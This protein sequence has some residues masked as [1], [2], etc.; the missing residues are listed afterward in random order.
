VPSTQTAHEEKIMKALLLLTLALTT[1][2]F[3]GGG[4]GFNPLPEIRK[5]SIICDTKSNS[6]RFNRVHFVFGEDRQGNSLGEIQLLDM[7]TRIIFDNFTAPAVRE[8]LFK[9]RTNNVRFQTISRNAGQ[10]TLA[11]SI[12]G[13]RGVEARLVIRNENLSIKSENVF[14][15]VSPRALDLKLDNVAATFMINGERVQ[16]TCQING[17]TMKSLLRPSLTVQDL[18]K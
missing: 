17:E 3:A 4:T 2:A 13:V 8:V 9:N 1:T 12:Q 14:F 16:S 18:L 7:E 11:M 10:V 15:E 6:D 5:S